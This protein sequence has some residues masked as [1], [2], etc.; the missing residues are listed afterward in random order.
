MCEM[1]LVLFC[2]REF[3]LT[4]EDTLKLFDE[5]IDSKPKD[6]YKC[7]RHYASEKLRKKVTGRCI[8]TNCQTCFVKSLGMLNVV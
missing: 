6:G 8:G 7:F 4:F 5:F 3:G 1:G 2:R